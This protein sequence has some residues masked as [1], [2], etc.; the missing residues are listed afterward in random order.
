M[1]NLIVVTIVMMSNNAMVMIA[2]VLVRDVRQLADVLIGQSLHRLSKP[3][4]MRDSTAE[5]H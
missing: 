2:V 5:E 3:R 1:L 4:V